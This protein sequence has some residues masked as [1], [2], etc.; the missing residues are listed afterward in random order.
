MAIPGRDPSKEI[1]EPGP[2]S[3]RAGGPDGQAAGPLWAQDGSF[4]VIRRLRQDVPKFR[5]FMASQAQKLAVDGDL[6]TAA[7][8]G[9]WKSGA[10]VIRTPATDIPALGD[11][12]CAN[13]HFEFGSPSNP[14]TPPVA[15][16]SDRLC[17]DNVHPQSPGDVPGSRCPF[18]A[19]I[20]K[21]Y[22]RDDTQLPVV[23][24]QGGTTQYG[25]PTA[26]TATPLPGGTLGEST[27][28]T[29]RMLRR[30]IPFGPPYNPAPDPS[31]DRDTGER[32]LLFV[33]Y[34]TSIVDQFEFVTKFWINNSDFKEPM[35]ADG[36]VKSGHDL[37]IGQ[38]NVGGSR[39]RKSL[40]S[41]N[42]A[43][44][45]VEASSTDEWVIP[46]GGGYFFAPSIAALR[47]LCPKND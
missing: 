25:T 18:A 28:Q 12:D 5:Q 43:E 41:V 29:H 15:E 17:Q 32:G 44:H 31:K 30:G 1:T 34:Q 6:L 39:A 13:N 22:P 36:T 9:R 10:P 35:G 16:G 8:V 33:S 45:V 4:V 27:T 46:T 47:L 26:P 20:R 11:D 38:S 3:L 42:G 7:I 24:S 23:P 40:I 37:V 2:D 19:H 14:I 21:A